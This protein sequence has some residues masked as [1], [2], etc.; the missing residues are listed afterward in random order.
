MQ[1]VTP[2]PLQATDVSTLPSSRGRRSRIFGVLTG[3]QEFW[4]EVCNDKYCSIISLEFNAD[5]YNKGK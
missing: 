3:T 4:A 5:F 2:Y 1:D